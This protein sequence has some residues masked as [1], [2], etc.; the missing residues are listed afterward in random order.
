MV[1]E[2]VE[3]AENFVGCYEQAL[4]SPFEWPTCRN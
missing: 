1:T 4:V 3:P 2:L